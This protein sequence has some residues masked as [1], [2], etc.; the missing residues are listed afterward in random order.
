[1]K[2]IDAINTF[3]T[4]GIINIALKA[5]TIIFFHYDIVPLVMLR[6]LIKLSENGESG[7]EISQKHYMAV[8][9]QR[10]VSATSS[11]TLGYSTEILP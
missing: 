1:M 8:V 11:K 9:Y 10:D 2:T 4:A 5:P 3:A 6:L 7:I